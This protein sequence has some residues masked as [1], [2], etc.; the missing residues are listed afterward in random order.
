MSRVLRPVACVIAAT[1][2]ATGVATAVLNVIGEDARHRPRARPVRCGAVRDLRCRAR[3]GRAVRGAAAAG[4]SHRVD[5]PRRLAVGRRG[6]RRLRRRRPGARARSRL[7]G[8]RLGRARVAAVAGAVPVAARAR[9]RVPGRPAAIASLAAGRGPRV[10][11]L[12]R[13]DVAAAV[14]ARVRHQ[15]R[16]HREPD[17]VHVAAQPGA[18]VLGLLGGPAGVARRR[19]GCA[20]RPLPRRRR[21]AA[22]AGPVAGVRRGAGADLARRR[23]GRRAR[24]RIDRR[25]R[26]LR[27]HDPAGVAGG[28]RRGRRHAPRPVRDR[29]AAQPHARLCRADGAAGRDLRARR[30]ARRPRRRRL[31][32]VCVGRDDRCGARVPAAARAHPDARRPPVRPRTVRRGAPPARLPRPGARRQRRAGGG[33]RRGSGRARGPDAPRSCSGCPRPAPTRTATAI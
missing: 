32:A 24:A 13:A 31:G 29:P 27:H 26:F 1:A 20:L 12:R 2:V 15:L 6:D 9:L 21:P 5:P 14:R 18:R 23:V 28:R 11:R 33:R 30:A 3:V 10:R 16:E 17:A 8:G 25:R 7:V 19:S 4:Q 22:A